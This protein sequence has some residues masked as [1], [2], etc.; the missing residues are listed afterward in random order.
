MS[1]NKYWMWELP[2][3]IDGT[4]IIV[5]AFA[6]TT[7][8]P[9]ILSKKPKKL[10]IINGEILDKAKKIYPD[11]LVIGES[12]TLPK[13]TF[14]CSNF[15]SD[16]IKCKFKNKIVLYMSS[17]GTKAIESVWRLTNHTV[18]CSFNNMLA[19]KKY[20]HNKKENNI[21]V[22]MAGEFYKKVLEDQ[23]C[24]EAII[25]EIKEEK[26]SWSDVSD[27]LIEY[28]KFH[29]KAVRKDFQSLDL[30]LN[31]NS[32]NIVPGLFKNNNS[33]LEVKSL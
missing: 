23:L 31:K 10:I 18:S 8:I 3:K 14:I 22:V 11:G 24:A 15:P 9:I 28:I 13:K 16:I 6:A 32:Y 17:N 7:N 25:K 2:E 29:Y 30:T 4:A 1:I 27:K 33:F 19:V 20:I 5:D 26:Y 12:T 21:T